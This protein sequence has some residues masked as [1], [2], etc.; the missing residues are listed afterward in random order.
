MVAALAFLPLVNWLPGGHAA[1]WYSTVL[2][3]WTSGSAIVVGLALVLAIVSR[4]VSGVWRDGA[5]EPV[6]AWANRHAILFG[7]VLG[8]A[9]LVLYAVVAS[10]V[11]SRVPI[12]I[13][14]LVQLVQAKTFAAGRLWQPASAT[15]EFYSVLNVVDADGR[16]YGQF[17]PGVQ[18]CSR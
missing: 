17:P 4:R 7:L 13:D 1:P 3:E 2:T 9:S 18:P 16:Y 15:P 6:S 12:S 11:F 14:E 8:G 5:L 10:R